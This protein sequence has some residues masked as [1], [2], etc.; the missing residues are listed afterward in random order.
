MSR[1]SHQQLAQRDLHIEFPEL[2]RL[3]KNPNN[4]RIRG[5]SQY[6]ALERSITEFGFVNPVL[7]D[8]EYRVICGHGRLEAARRLGMEHVPVIRLSHLSEVQRRAY[9]IADN[10][11]AEKSG[12]SK[13]LLRSELQGLVELGYDAELTGFDTV[14]IDTLLS[15][16]GDASKAA[17]DNEQVEL[18]DEREPLSRL[19]DHW[20]VGRHHLLVGDARDPNAYEQLLAGNRAE[21][22]FTDPPYNAAARNISGLGKVRHGPFVMGSGE[23][24]DGDFVMHLLR[25]AMR[26]IVRFSA[27]GAIA[28]FCSDWRS[29]RPIW[30]AAEGVF[31]APKNLITWA[32]TNAGMGSFY[33][34][35]T[36]YIVPFLVSKG[37]VINNMMLAKG[38]RHRSTLWTYPGCNTFRRGRMEDLAEHPTVKPRKLVA[39]A[40]LDVSRPGSIV[41]DPF[42]G[43]G[44]TLAAAEVTGRVGYGLEL[45]PK[46]ADVCL[47]RMAA[48]TGEMPRLADGTSLEAVAANRAIKWMEA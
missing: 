21:C 17:D 6:R 38:K 9:I 31:V 28:F 4:S 30:D 44:T 8:D 26:N 27:P 16:E 11:L 40:L 41:L 20:L 25:P 7:V 34:Q 22:T 45:D 36:E 32:K 35:Q 43:S 13:E 19:C 24:S 23:L 33:R 1:K 42:L 3:Q 5:E 14:E 29:L 47:R 18:P 12:W 37:E 2:G 10:A 46:Y 39:D 15:F 48:L